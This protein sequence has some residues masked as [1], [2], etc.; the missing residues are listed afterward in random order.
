MVI[1]WPRHNHYHHHDRGENRYS[2]PCPVLS[3]CSSRCYFAR[4]DDADAARW[5]LEL[6]GASR[7]V[8]TDTLLLLKPILMCQVLLEQRKLPESG[9]DDQSIELLLQELA[10]MDSNNFVGNV[11]VGEVC[12][13][14]M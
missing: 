8:A 1:A 4:R 11:G 12:A 10:V 7:F 9:W 14:C 2:F 13:T 3:A 5:L 6:D